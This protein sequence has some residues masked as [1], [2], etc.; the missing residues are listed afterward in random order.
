MKKSW[1]SDEDKWMERKL[2]DRKEGKG[3]QKEGKDY[4]KE[5]EWWKGE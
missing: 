1:W 4:Q 3:G 2:V 5:K